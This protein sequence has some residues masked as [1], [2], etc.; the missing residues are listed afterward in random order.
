MTSRTGKSTYYNYTGTTYLTDTTSRMYQMLF[1]DTANKN[2]ISY[3][4]ASRCM[5][6]ASSIEYFNARIVNNNSVA[7]TGL[8]NG[9][10]NGFFEN[11]LSYGV[12]PIVYL[13]S[14]LKTSG[15]D[16]NGAWKI[17]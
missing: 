6:S 2:N 7:G 17:N 14:N 5:D 9:Y 12:R 3:W 16:I 15:K 1:R 4:L 10:N 13:Q 8:G 11:S